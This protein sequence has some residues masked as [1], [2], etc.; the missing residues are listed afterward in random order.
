MTKDQGFSVFAILAAFLFGIASGQPDPVEARPVTRVIKIVPSHDKV[1]AV[2][3][4]PLPEPRTCYEPP[5]FA[6]PQ[7]PKDND[8]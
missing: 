2:L 6:E 1:R 4:E 3:T 8:F 7:L 5:L